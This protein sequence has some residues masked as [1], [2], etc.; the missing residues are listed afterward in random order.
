MRGIS[1]LVSP[2]STVRSA[3]G[4]SGGSVRM[5]LKARMRV[6]PTMPR[7]MVKML[8]VRSQRAS[9]RGTSI[10]M[11]ALPSAASSMR[12]TRPIGKP[13]NVR[14]MPTMT[15]SESSATSTSSCVLSNTPRAYITY[16]KKP[17]TKPLTT[18]SSRMALRSTRAI[19]EGESGGGGA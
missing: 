4:G 9:L 8:E 5:P 11:R 6:S 15:P 3:P 16:S 2:R 10:T 14:S 1:A 18:I 7:S 13:E 19:A 17:S 12:L